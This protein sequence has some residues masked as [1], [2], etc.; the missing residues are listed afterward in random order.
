MDEEAYVER[1]FALLNREKAA[2]KSLRD[3]EENV[4]KIQRALQDV[5]ASLI[6]QKEIHRRES[7]NI[8]HERSV[9]EL[10][11]QIIFSH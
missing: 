3:S 6:Q 11:F 8:R 2:N 9:S 5:Q 7:D 10:R 1:L 4:E